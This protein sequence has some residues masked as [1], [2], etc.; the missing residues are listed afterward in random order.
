MPDKNAGQ[1]SFIYVLL[2]FKNVDNENMI[3]YVS[4][5][6]III[7]IIINHL[8]SKRLDLPQVVMDWGADI[9]PTNT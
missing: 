1:L 4:M 7:I 9:T 5:H 2:L 8:A 6:V 3:L